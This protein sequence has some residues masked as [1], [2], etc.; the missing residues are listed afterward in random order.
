[1]QTA[2]LSLPPI[3]EMA[4]PIQELK[5]KQPGQVEQ[6]QKPALEQQKLLETLQQLQEKIK[7]QAILSLKSGGEEPRQAEQQMHTKK[8]IPEKQRQLEI[9]QQLQQQIQTGAMPLEQNPIETSKQPLQTQVQEKYQKLVDANIFSNPETSSLTLAANTEALGGVSSAAE[10]AVPAPPAPGGSMTGVDSGDGGSPPVATGTEGTEA[11]AAATGPVGAAAVAAAAAAGA[12][13]TV[14]A[15]MSAG[16]IAAVATGVAAAAAAAAVVSSSSANNVA[17]TNAANTAV[18]Q[19]DPKTGLT[20][21]ASWPAS[22]NATFNG[23]LSGTLSDSSAV[24]G[25]LS[26]NVNFATI[27]SGGAIPGNIQFDNSKGSA[28]LSLVQIGGF[29]GGG[30]T[31]TYNGEA[32]NG[33]IRNGQFYGPAANAVKGTWDMTTSSISGGGTFAATR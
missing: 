20:P 16:A 32:M 22:L 10:R 33:F 8:P 29:V 27:G 18:N 13:A 15:G 2:P 11:G 25:N 4:Q 12:P 3:Q 26:M 24:G 23:R 7:Q 6:T 28:T 9:L 17:Q 19:S 1:M 5:G 31:G 30:M 14:A 21:R